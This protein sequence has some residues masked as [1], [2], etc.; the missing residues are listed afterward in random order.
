[1]SMAHAL[2]TP[3]KIVLCAAA[4]QAAKRRRKIVGRFPRRSRGSASARTAESAVSPAGAG[5]LG[6]VRCVPRLRA[7]SKARNALPRPR[8]TQPKTTTASPSQRLGAR[9]APEARQ[10]VRDR[11]PGRAVVEV[12]VRLRRVARAVEVGEHDVEVVAMERRLA[13]ERAAARAAEAPGAVLRRP[14]A[15]Q[16][17]LA[18]DDPEALVRHPD[19]RDVAG[20]MGATAHRAVAVGAEERRRL[21]LEAH[22]TTETGA[23]DGRGRH[24]PTLADL[25]PAAPWRRPVRGRGSPSA[26]RRRRGRSRR[27]R[28]TARAA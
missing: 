13:E 3:W 9:L 22:R 21:D 18:G 17:L 8:P 14:V 12:E 26:R 2:L 20:A 11:H 27:P 16:P 25:S 23:G 4:R 28:A 19:P 6:E 7:T 5:S 24:A 10:V 15:H 1:M